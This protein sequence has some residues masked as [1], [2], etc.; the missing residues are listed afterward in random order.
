ME[1]AEIDGQAAS[2][3]RSISLLVSLKRIGFSFQFDE[4]M[5]GPLDYGILI[6]T[7]RNDFIRAGSAAGAHQRAFLVARCVYRL[8]FVSNSLL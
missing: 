2:E 4:A 6:R 7:S 8:F 3:A 1:I 5:N